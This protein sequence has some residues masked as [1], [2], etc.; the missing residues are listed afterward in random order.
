MPEPARFDVVIVGAGPAG[1]GAAIAASR[2]TSSIAIVDQNS[3]AGGQIWRPD[4]DVPVRPRVGKVITR[5]LDAV[6]HLAGATVVDAWAEGGGY[7]LLI[8]A[9]GQTI[10][11]Q[12]GT[13]VLATGAR[14]LFLPFPGWTLQGVVGAGGLQALMKSGLDVR[15]K[16]VVVSGTGPLLVAVAATAA[17]KG[18][19]VVGVVEQVPLSGMG[20][21]ALGLLARPAVA[22][23]GLR[24]AQQ[25]PSGTMRLG[26]WVATAHG[27]DRVTGVTIQS[28]DGSLSQIDCD[29]LATG[30][31]L[32]PNVE[33]PRLLGCGVTTAGVVVDDAQ[34]TTVAG[35]FAA[36][37][38]TGIGGEAKSGME[39]LVAGMAAVGKQ[40]ARSMRGQRNRERRWGATL[41]RT[42]ALRPEVLSLAMPDTIVCRCED[43]R[44]R[45]LSSA[46]TARQAKLYARAGMGACQGRVCG[47]ALEAMF[48]WPMDSTR[49]PLHPVALSSLLG[50]D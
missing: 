44:L 22:L 12:T 35:V 30:Y 26:S 16:R 29:Y 37:E 11:L 18:A 39:G 36:G 15:G 3:E 24:Y 21:F 9:A 32:I 5:A 38:C 23:E 4:R 49:A 25:L 34:A 40:A 2:G 42:F 8:D 20:R 6:T 43:V 10:L 19:E 46:S 7:R 41:A 47:S 31:G 33:L 50:V 45:D 13:I 27:N 14:E 17:K 1:L 48:G 28:Q